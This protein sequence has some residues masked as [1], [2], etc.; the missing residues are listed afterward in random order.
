METLTVFFFYGAQL[1]PY[2]IN[3][4]WLNSKDA[5]IRIVFGFYVCLRSDLLSLEID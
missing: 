4:F 3:A 5:H 2:F 1:F